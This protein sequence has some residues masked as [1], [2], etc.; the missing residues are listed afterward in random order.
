MQYLCPYSLLTVGVQ[1][2]F[3]ILEHGTCDL[4]EVLNLEGQ[5]K[6]PGSCKAVSSEIGANPNLGFMQGI[7]NNSTDLSSSK[8]CLKILATKNMLPCLD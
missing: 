5:G 1:H 6:K 4:L 3:C 7:S 2:C 8:N